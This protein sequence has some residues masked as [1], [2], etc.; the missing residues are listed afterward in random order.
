MFLLV[1]FFVE[2]P[3]WENLQVDRF[4]GDKNPLRIWYPLINLILKRSKM[5]FMALEDFSMSLCS[6]HGVVGEGQNCVARW[7]FQTFFVFIPT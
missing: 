2:T 7:V 3:D 6:Q 1:S 4:F 5:A